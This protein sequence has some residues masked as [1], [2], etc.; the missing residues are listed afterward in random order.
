MIIFGLIKLAYSVMVKIGLMLGKIWSIN[1]N[2]VIFLRSQSP[3]KQ[4][5]S[6]ECNHFKNIK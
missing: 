1:L 3:K 2:A 4:D 5:F 6:E